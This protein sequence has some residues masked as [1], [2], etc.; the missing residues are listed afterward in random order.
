MLLSVLLG[1]HRTAHKLSLLSLEFAN[2]EEYKPIMPR[3]QFVGA[4]LVRHSIDNVDELQ[5]SLE[6]AERDGQNI[7]DFE[8]ASHA[9]CVQS[10]YGYYSG[11]SLPTLDKKLERFCSSAF[12]LSQTTPSS[13]LRLMRQS[14][15]HL[16]N[17][18][19]TEP[20]FS[21]P[22]FDKKELTEN[23]LWGK[24]QHIQALFHL[25]CLHLQLL[26]KNPKKGDKH[27]TEAFK[28]EE[29]ILGFSLYSELLFLDSLCKLEFAVTGDGSG[30]KKVNANIK[31][32]KK[33]GAEGNDNHR[34]KIYLLNAIQ[35]HLKGELE[36]ALIQ[37]ALAQKESQE[38][39]QI[40]QEYFVS[41][42]LEIFWKSN[43]NSDLEE[44]YGE[45]AVTALNRWGAT[46]IVLALYPDRTW[47]RNSGP[48]TTSSV[49]SSITTTQSLD[50]D[51]IMKAS[52]I[53]SKE[54][55]LDKLLENMMEL[56]LTN[57]G[58]CRGFFIVDKQGT[59]T[60]EACAETNSGELHIS[61]QQGIAVRDEENLSHSILNY[62]MRTGEQ[63]ILD[64]AHKNPLFTSD[65]YLAKSRVPSI[66]CTPIH[67][68]NRR[69]GIIYLE[70]TLV[71]KAFTVERLE[72]LSL[73]STEMAIS[74]ENAYLY[75]DLE[76]INNRLEKT[77][78]Q[79]TQELQEVAAE[80]ITQKDSV[81]KLLLNILPRRVVQ[82]LKE[83]GKTESESFKG[84]AVF[85]SDLVGFTSKTANLPAE[86]VI[87]E[88]NTLFTEF[89]AIMERHGCE[90]IKTIG[91]GY[92]A[93]CGIP[94][95]SPTAVNHLVAA[96]QDILD[97]LK[98]RNISAEHAWEAR[99]GIHCGDIVGGVVGVRK[100][101]YDIFGDTINTAS[102]MES[103][104][105]PMRI[106]LSEVA[107]NIAKS[108]FE[109][110]E[111]GSLPIKG[112]GDMMMYFVK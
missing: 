37:F 14:V 71:E 48:S 54:I 33:L 97:F 91:D 94:D 75:T 81:D 98:M 38:H 105:E 89:D 24:N 23:S 4:S 84:V 49:T 20:L 101:I 109:V 52:R 82:N 16:Q 66:Y 25:Q 95:Y 107:A 93:V 73:L 72:L 57:A 44:F 110:I 79:R 27:A 39:Q 76:E 43:G 70:N 15:Y 104:S 92:M 112:K 32:L 2:R 12:Q 90:R 60:I 111:R 18:P 59:L 108:Q 62:A 88:L 99:I 106:N 10:Y 28:F 26:L 34:G 55:R 53:L 77:V 40:N 30:L 6:I 31:R 103:N 78:L 74:I 45:A 47:I 80:L 11:K 29:G 22:Y 87:N 21:G 35:L 19:T 56:V 41:H 3:T 8:F 9:M 67:H 85:F 46:G 96:A 65:Q 42:W 17:N 64:S 61:V 63:L 102:R 51:V 58:A 36:K 1:W 50:F 100:Y 69:I 86:T 83:T 7:G 5:K 13:F 68:K